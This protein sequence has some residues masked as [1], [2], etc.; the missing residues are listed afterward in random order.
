MN[1]HHQM[2]LSWFLAV[3]LG[4]GAV[5]SLSIHWVLSNHRY[6]PHRY[7]GIGGAVMA[8]IDTLVAFGAGATLGVHLATWIA[9]RK[10]KPPTPWRWYIDVVALVV[11]AYLVTVANFGH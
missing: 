3:C 10:E 8:L 6:G 2:L 1:R 9:T 11:L 4:A 7:S 5:S